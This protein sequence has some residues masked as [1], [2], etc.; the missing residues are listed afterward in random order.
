MSL[1]CFP[2]PYFFS[3]GITSERSRGCC[4]NQHCLQCLSVALTGQA[5]LSEIEFSDNHIVV[6]QDDHVP[7]RHLPGIP[8][9]VDNSIVNKGTDP[10]HTRFLA[11]GLGRCTVASRKPN[12]VDRKKLNVKRGVFGIQ[13]FLNLLQVAKLATA[14]TSCAVEEIPPRDLLEIVSGG[15]RL[16]VAG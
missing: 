1:G 9:V 10:G 5:V 3:C 13:L 16:A 7:E 15:N 11:A 6:I 8:D 12:L 4:C 2:E 14:V